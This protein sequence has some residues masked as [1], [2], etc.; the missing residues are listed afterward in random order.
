MAPTSKLQEGL[1]QEIV[2]RIQQT[3]MSP[4]SF[5][6]GFWHYTRTVEG[7][8]YEIYC[9]RKESMDAFEEVEL[10]VNELAQGHDYFD[11]GF[12]EHSQDGAMLAYAVD[13]IGNEVH[14]LRFRDLSTG[15]DLEDVLED[16][17]YGSA[18]RSRRTCSSCRKTTS[19]LSSASS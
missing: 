13:L 9:R 8:D 12:V 14:Q 1:Y 6:K 16:V 18:P 19:A 7:L 17:Y 15:Q 3:D 2:G 11:L 4:P 10:D 5:F